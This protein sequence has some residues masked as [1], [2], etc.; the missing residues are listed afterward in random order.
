MALPRILTDMMLY[1]EGQSFMGEVSS[2]VLP[3]L[4]RKTEDWRGGGMFAP[5]KLDMGMEGLEMEATFGGPMRDILRQ[6]GV[7]GIAGV[8]QRFVG[9]Y[10][11]QDTGGQD[12]VEVIVRG[13]HDEID[14]GEAKPGEAGEFKVKSSL[15]YYKEVWN[16]RTEIE[17]DVMNMVQIINGVDLMA[18]RR[19]ALGLF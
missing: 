13:R 5:V 19:T 1:N 12:A 3:K 4:V 6:F 7:T 9:F 10:Q 14:R 15:V 2:I 17:I 16:G 18:A 8:Y 11:Q